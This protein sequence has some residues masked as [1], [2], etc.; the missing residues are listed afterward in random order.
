[1]NGWQVLWRLALHFLLV[2]LVLAL[3]M[4]ALFVATHAV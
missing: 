4:G 3:T 2:G 1:M